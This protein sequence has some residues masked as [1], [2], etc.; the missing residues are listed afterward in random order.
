MWTLLC[1]VSWSSLSSAKTWT[2]EPG[3]TPSFETVANDLVSDGDEIVL[4]PG[5]FRADINLYGRSNLTIRGAGS[6]PGGTRIEGGA[7]TV[8]MLLARGSKNIVLQS[9]VMTG[10]DRVRVLHVRDGSTAFLDDVWLQSGRDTSFEGGAGLRVDAGSEVT[11]ERSTFFDNTSDFDGT[12]W[13]EG[14]AI[15]RDTQFIANEANYGAGMY[16]GTGSTCVVED[17]TFEA[18]V[19]ERGPGL[20]LWGGAAATV[21]RSTFCLNGEPAKQKAGVGGTLLVNGTPTV[22]SNSVFL[23]NSLL[24]DGAGIYV[25]DAPVQVLNNTFASNA[26]GGGGAALFAIGP[27]ASVTATNNLIVGNVTGAA[28]WGGAVEARDQATLQGS[29]NLM[30]GNTPRDYGDQDQLPDTVLADPMLL[31]L[32]PG[33][34]AS[35]VLPS[36][37]GPASDAGTSSPGPDWVDPDGTPADIGASGGPH[38][39]RDRDGDGVHDGRGADEDCN[40]LDDNQFPGNQ[41]VCSGVDED[42]DGAIDDADPS[43]DAT[44]SGI[45]VLVDA[46]GDGFSD[47]SEVEA[48]VAGEP[49][50]TGDCDDASDIVFPGAP[51]VCDLVDND[52]DALVDEQCPGRP[53]PVD[54]GDIAGCSCGTG[55]PLEGVLWVGALGLAMGRRRR[56]YPDAS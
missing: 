19:A 51:E 13:V 39:K 52:C 50:P 5:T 24:D 3:G 8:I 31:G 6:G 21:R 37:E 20:V 42:C 33:D 38:A 10:E 48:C 49:L 54:S 55:G 9:F 7:G 16:C 46:D 45:F 18:G 29:H 34:C 32:V 11:V 41:E 14:T 26:S 53:S 4:G 28:E 12:L 27:K 23:F 36:D 1:V 25:F 2:L 43:V 15:V 17:S 40:D 35:S 56:R 44:G 47:G 22:V 30:W